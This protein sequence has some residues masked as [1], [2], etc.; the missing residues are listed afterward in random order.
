MDLDWEKVCRPKTWGSLTENE[1]AEV[2]L[3]MNRTSYTVEEV[4][5]MLNEQRKHIASRFEGQAT[6]ISNRVCENRVLNSNEYVLNLRLGIR[7]KE[8]V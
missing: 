1:R 7:E 4:Y 6:L 8:N 5:T 3:F 2:M